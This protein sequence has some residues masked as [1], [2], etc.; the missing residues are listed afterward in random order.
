MLCLVV[1]WGERGL[2]RAAFDPGCCGDV[3]MES[4]YGGEAEGARAE[5]EGDVATVGAG[6]A[7]EVE[8]G[9]GEVS[10]ETGEGAAALFGEACL[11]P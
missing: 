8:E 4:D 6:E 2:H 3:V 1:G 7:E 5:E 9:L 10:L 11:E